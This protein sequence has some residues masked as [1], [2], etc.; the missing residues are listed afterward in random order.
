MELARHCL[1][2][3]AK[4]KASDVHFEPFGDH[5]LIRFRIHGTLTDWKKLPPDHIEPLTNK[6]KWVLGLDL[7]VVSK[8]QDGRASFETLGFDARVNSMPV[9]GNREKIVIRLQFQEQTPKLE[10]MG[11]ESSAISVLRSNIQKT[12]GLIVISGPTG[13]GKTTTLYALLEEMDRLG[14]NISTLENPVEKHLERINQSNVEGK[15][16]FYEF[17]RALMRQDPDIILTR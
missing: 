3:A 1:K 14:K 6:L 5:Y 13:S 17:Q 9:S 16:D 2:E 7:A 15:E 8:P 4:A 11:F 12:E 10:E